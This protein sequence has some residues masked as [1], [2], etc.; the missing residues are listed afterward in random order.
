MGATF[1]QFIACGA[2]M[3]QVSMHDDHNLEQIPVEASQPSSPVFGIHSPNGWI[4]T[5]I[6]FR[7][8][9]KVSKDQTT[10]L[11]AAMA[12]WEKAV[13]KKL[14]ANNGIQNNIDGDSFKD[15]YSSLPD[16]INGNYL[17]AN[18]GKTGKPVE[19]LA[20]TIWDNDPKSGNKIDTAD[21]RFNTQHYQIGDS[22]KLKSN[23]SQEVVDMQS[24]ALHEL[25]HLLGLAHVQSKDDDLSIM[26]PSLYIGEGFV[27]R[28]LSLGDIMRIQKIY[29]CEGR[30]CDANA[31]HQEIELD[32][33]NAQPVAKK[34]AQK[35]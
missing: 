3:Y 27:A 35:T 5:P 24:L 30:A 26:N 31:I 21:I 32:I 34:A 9:S 22:Y 28:K 12:T 20:T 17:D 23:K 6:E 33:D 8:G 4:K 16:R 7:M 25:G 14:F 13:G 18:W 2:Q 29:G 15:L 10:Q 1:T 11:V 19:V